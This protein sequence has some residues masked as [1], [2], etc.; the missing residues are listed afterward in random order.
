MLNILDLSKINGKKSSTEIKLS[1]LFSLSVLYVSTISAI[2]NCVLGLNP[3]IN[4]AIFS[5]YFVH[6]FFL[7]TTFKGK[8]KENGRFA[9]YLFNLCS[10]V[11]VWFLNGGAQGCV[12]IFIIFYLT[13]AILSLSNKC[14]NIYILFSI[15]IIGICIASEIYFPGLITRYPNQKAHQL[16]LTFALINVILACIFILT[17]YKKLTDYDQF[18][19]ITSKKRLET[20]QQELL[21][22]KDVAESATKAKS[23]FLTNMS[24]EIRTPLNGIIGASELLKLTDLNTEQ[25][26]LVN[27]LQASNGILIDIVNDLL[28]ISRIEANKMEIHNLPFNF[29]NCLKD[30]KNIVKPIF[31]D[32]NIKLIFEISNNTPDFIISDEIKIKQILINLLSN[33]VKF[34]DLGLVTLVVNYSDVENKPMLLIE[35]NDTGIGIDAEDIKKLFQPFSQVNPNDTRKFGGAGLGLVI[36]RKLTEMMG[37][38]ISLESKVNSGSTFK[39]AIPI[40]KHDQV[41]LLKTSN[42]IGTKTVASITEMHILIAEDNAFNQIIISKMLEKSGYKFDLANDGLEALD[43]VNKQHYDIILMDMQMPEMDGLRATVEILKTYQSRGMEPPVIIGCTANAMEEDKNAC[44]SA[45]M[46]DF[47]PK[48]FTLADLK[49]ILSK[50]AN[51]IK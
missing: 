41:L 34:T 4:L 20:S 5:A 43:K 49:S 15:I 39:V 3:N 48:P 29:R 23:K 47:L 8:V 33:A 27:M 37:G 2:I 32:K 10:L 30:A 51:E 35:V 18:L 42:P 24:H 13:I 21:L 31:S 50:W 36:C 17:F 28:D 19:L 12:P 1:I 11:P 9:Y 16:D 7:Y 44:S 38:K 40:K 14:K 45:G 25:S 46:K 26:E 6:A 22:A